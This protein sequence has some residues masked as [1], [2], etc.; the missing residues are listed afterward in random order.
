MTE[1][2]H[3][4]SIDS[5]KNNKPL[6]T[7]ILHLFRD[8]PFSSACVPSNDICTNPSLKLD[9]H[10]HKLYGYELQTQECLLKILSDSLNKE[11]S[12]ELSMRQWRI[13]C[14]YE[15]II[16]IHRISNTRSRLIHAKAL[17]PECILQSTLYTYRDY[18]ESLHAPQD[19]ISALTTYI[20]SEVCKSLDIS[21]VKPQ[22][23][24]NNR[25]S[26]IEKGQE[27]ISCRN[28]LSHRIR[29]RLFSLKSQLF[30]FLYH[31][32][33]TTF[34]PRAII[35][36]GSYTHIQRLKLLFKGVYYYPSVFTLPLSTK[37]YSARTALQKSC[38]NHPLYSLLDAN[39]KL[40]LNMFVELMSTS[41]LEDY[42]R[43]NEFSSKYKLPTLR[44]ILSKHVVHYGNWFFKHLLVD[45]I[46]SG[47]K[48]INIQ[49]GGGYGTWQH[50]VEEDQEKLCSDKFMYW[51]LNRSV[52]PLT[53][54][55]DKCLVYLFSLIRRNIRTNKILFL[56]TMR[57][58]PSVKVLEGPMDEL[59]PLYYIQQQN[60]F[61]TIS[62]DLSGN[63]YYKPYPSEIVYCS[64]QIWYQSANPK[65]VPLYCS[66]FQDAY[67][68]FDLFIY[69]HHG[70]GWL[71]SFKAN[72]PTILVF[73]STYTHQNEFNETLISLSKHKFLYNSL[74]ELCTALDVGL[75]YFIDLWF[76]YEMQK[77]RLMI[78]YSYSPFGPNY[79]MI[80]SYVLT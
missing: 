36:C 24:C 10:K 60:F 1:T 69:D 22:I 40:I 74:S 16:L 30:N 75:D 8:I 53:K 61:D 57:T 73:D 41:L 17:Y 6:N 63:I 31:L 66:S 48:F 26:D 18:E 23:S 21:L 14:G 78:I 20:T 13:F 71:E 58:M 56:S 65:K 15:L 37:N 35:F 4:I 2:Y 49:H 47:G 70:T 32:F 11:H 77:L 25:N 42:H 54:K 45:H 68:H 29:Q 64:E 43:F 38:A 59:I 7:T 28:D 39:S 46:G 3:I 52:N 76:S 62:S 44:L 19:D 67:R 27:F 51:G 5:E 72:K 34:N 50:M 9:F 80:N 55:F 79:S 12:T 33:R